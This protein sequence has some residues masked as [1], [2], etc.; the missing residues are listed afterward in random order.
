MDKQHSI[1]EYISK[2]E[3]QGKEWTA[4]FVEYMRNNH[5][6][7]EE[8]ISFQMPTFK[9]G[10]RYDIIGRNVDDIVLY[11]AIENAENR[12]VK[13]IGAIREPCAKT[14]TRINK[15]LVSETRNRG[16]LCV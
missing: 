7:L 8:V 13:P 3:G 2:L 16:L 11:S 15:A 4:F 14:N 10:I 5:N 12:R 6:D 1:D 9:L